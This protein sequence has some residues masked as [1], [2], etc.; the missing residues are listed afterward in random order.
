MNGHSHRPPATETPTRQR[1][2]GTLR[3]ATAAL[4]LGL[5]AACS[6]ATGPGP[7]TTSDITTF[8]NGLPSWDQ[9][10]PLEPETSGEP[11]GQPQ[12][13]LEKV[14]DG[15]LYRCTT[16]RYSITK[17]PTDIVMANPNAAT[18]WPGAL[19]HGESH[20][21]AALRPLALDRSRRAPLGI[22]VEGGG[23][24]GIRGGVSTVV[25]EPV[26][27]TVREGIN[28]LIANALDSD[29]AV[30]A[31]F[32]Q[33]KS[34]ESHSASQATLEVGLSARY[35]GA[36]ASAEL[37]YQRAANEH[38]FTASF[39]QRLFTISIDLPESPAAFFSDSVTAQDLQA[40]GINAN[41]LPLYISSV[42]YGRIL[43]FSFSST[44]SRERIEAALEFAYN[45]PVGGVG[46][47]A[48]TELQE[49]LQNAR[50]E[51]L[52]IGGPNAGVES[53][54]RNGDLSSYFEAEL[55]I[56]QV[57]PISFNINNLGNNSLARVSNTTEYD[58]ETCEAVDTVELPQPLHHWTGDG[59]LD[60]V[61]GDVPLG[62]IDESDL[63][64]AGR[65]GQAYL[66]DG[67]YDSANTWPVT[68]ILPRDGLF[69]LS[70]WVNPRSSGGTGTIISQVGEDWLG[71]DYSF[72]IINGTAQF[73]RR[74]SSG[75]NSVDFVQSASG[76]VPA[77]SWTHVV[78][79][80]GVADGEPTTMRLYVNGELA[81]ETV[82]TGTYTPT[83]GIQ[84]TR[85]GSGEL[86]SPCNGQCTHRYPFNGSID[87][88]M[89]F[90]S[91][92]T[93]DEVFNMYERFGDYMP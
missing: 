11:L 44:E 71:G 66:F 37:D 13:P 6:T 62:G 4:L 79:V 15:Q 16:Q 12:A 73:L 54:I 7:G 45:S 58:V 40:F 51:V 3:A 80:Y 50:I 23:V 78:A 34:V 48:E 74:P 91:P 90:E 76:T 86:I 69:S 8:V 28:Q 89:V 53:L 38:T 63:Y 92:L 22:S 65:F 32:S 21:S 31:G 39:I 5:L 59:A 9:L 52:A 87:E 14:A 72:R 70:A 42:S 25:V 10:S 64:G 75:S 24:L 67:I 93:A 41:N 18:I 29:V 84:L 43:M 35:L 81:S 55:E 57:E 17:N 60:D 27:S 36:S 85:V 88:L 61:A 77:G 33:F 56:N 46:G 49:T 83:S 20:L 47:Y 30:G 2:S 26:A 82:L 68:E 19:L 1:R